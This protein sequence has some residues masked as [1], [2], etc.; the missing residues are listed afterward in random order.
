[1]AKTPRKGTTKGFLKA[2][3]TIPLS[4][5]LKIGDLV[6]HINHGNGK[7]ISDSED[8]SSIIVEFDKAPNGWDKVL[9]VSITCL[10]RRSDF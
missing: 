10:R 1:M 7:I 6:T 9:E 2:L 4:K 3:N 8:T 5:P